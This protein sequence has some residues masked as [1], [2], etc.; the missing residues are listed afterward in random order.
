MLSFP[1]AVKLATA[2]PEI[3]SDSRSQIAGSSTI[4]SRAGTDNLIERTMIVQ[5][6]TLRAI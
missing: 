5:L 6:G 4:W 1:D 3:S 2:W